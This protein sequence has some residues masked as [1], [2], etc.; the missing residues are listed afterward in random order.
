[1]IKMNY[2]PSVILNTQRQN[3]LNSTNRQMQIINFIKCFFFFF[4][5]KHLP[6][7]FCFQRFSAYNTTYNNSN[8]VFKYFLSTCFN[9]VNLIIYIFNLIYISFRLERWIWRINFNERLLLLLHKTIYLIYF[10]FDSFIT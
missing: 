10:C 4:L 3:F 6:K 1:M 7:T 2:S 8:I 5:S 9:I